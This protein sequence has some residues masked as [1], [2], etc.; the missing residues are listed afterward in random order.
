MALHRGGVAGH[1]GGRRRRFGGHFARSAGGER[2]GGGDCDPAVVHV[3]ISISSTS[4]TTR[5]NAYSASVRPR[6][7][8]HTPIGRAP[9]REREWQ[10]VSIMVVVGL[11]KKIKIS[12]DTEPAYQIKNI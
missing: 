11:C 8:R 2:Q 9:D 3:A 10:Y 7:P 4:P 1:F 5:R 6:P 12:K